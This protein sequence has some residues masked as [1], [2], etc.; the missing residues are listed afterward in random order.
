MY[1]AYSLFSK[2]AACLEYGQVKNLEPKPKN[3]LLA[4]TLG[5]W[6]IFMDCIIARDARFYI[7]I[8]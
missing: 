1:Y 5:C 6:L 3:S 2:E 4:L 7:H 8:A